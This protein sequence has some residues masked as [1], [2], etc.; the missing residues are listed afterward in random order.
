MAERFT[1]LLDLY[2][3]EEDEAR[4]A[5]GVLER[6]RVEQF[7]RRAAIGREREAAASAAPLA[8]RDQLERFWARTGQELRGVESAIAATDAAIATA[9]ATLAD[10]HRKVAIFEKLRER[11]RRV[12]LRAGERREAR[13]LDEFAARRFVATT[14]QEGRP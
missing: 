9:R 4:R 7:E 1:A 12:A 10:A 14:R 8:L 6:Q 2:R 13:R 5:L 3:R 11:D